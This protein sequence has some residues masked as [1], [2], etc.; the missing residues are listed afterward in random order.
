MPLEQVCAKIV[1]HKLLPLVWKNG[2]DSLAT[3]RALSGDKAEIEKELAI[4][5]EQ[6][7]KAEER[8]ASFRKLRN[9]LRKLPQGVFDPG[10]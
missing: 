5:R 7:V 4:L 3:Y 10:A 8:L 6:R 1:R 2:A 9:R